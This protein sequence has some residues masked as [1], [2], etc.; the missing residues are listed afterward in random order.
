MTTCTEQSSW[1]VAS[2][3]SSSPP[4]HSSPRI[5]VRLV[6]PVYLKSSYYT[7]LSVDKSYPVE[8]F[9]ARVASNPE[10][11][12]AVSAIV[13]N[14][15]GSVPFL[16]F[17]PPGTGKTVTLVEA[18]KQVWQLNPSTHILVCAPSNT[19]ADLLT[20]RLSHHVPR[21]GE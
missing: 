10:Q 21:Q 15:S 8:C 19:A 7:L 17:G 3:S 11:L 2:T 14:S 20:V 6:D 18:I 13:N 12:A 4:P 1:P 16:V 5:K 9:D